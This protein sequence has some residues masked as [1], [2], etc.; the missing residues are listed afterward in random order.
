M[1]E[2]FDLLYRGKC[3]VCVA[4]EKAGVSPEEMKRLFRGYVA[5]RPINVN[6]PDVWLADVELGWPWS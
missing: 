4:A 2:A 3:N 1:E 6:D 5:E